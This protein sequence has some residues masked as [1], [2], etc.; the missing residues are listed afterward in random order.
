M[1]VAACSTGE[2][3]GFY[4]CWLPQAGVAVSIQPR[5]GG[6]ASTN[7]LWRCLQ[8]DAAQ[9]SPAI[10]QVLAPPHAVPG[11][12][13]RNPYWAQRYGLAYLYLTAACLRAVPGHA[14]W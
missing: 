11:K 10:A 12:R 3:W 2:G 14:R 9:T 8:T 4:L 5:G 6:G 13:Q 1:S 7:Y